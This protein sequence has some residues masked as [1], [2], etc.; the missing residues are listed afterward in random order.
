M[1]IRGL[2]RIVLACSICL[3]VCFS[4]VAQAENNVH[5]KKTDMNQ[6]EKGFTNEDLLEFP[7]SERDAYLTGAI[8]STAH[9]LSLFHSK[10]MGQCF[11]D[12][13]LEQPNNRIEEIEKE[14][15]KYPKHPPSTILLGLPQLKC[16]RLKPK[17]VE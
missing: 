3:L 5:Q 6:K 2:G 10:E 9:T 15:Q 4:F 8:L 14:M 17:K 12:W 1:K 13:F 7:K 16:G 11:S